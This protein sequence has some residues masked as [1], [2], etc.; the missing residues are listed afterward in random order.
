MTGESDPRIGIA[1]IE[2]ATGRGAKKYYG[3]ASDMYIWAFS[4]QISD[5]NQKVVMQEAERILPLLADEEV[6]VGES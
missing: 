1:F 2:L 5:N 4:P 3:T 6:S